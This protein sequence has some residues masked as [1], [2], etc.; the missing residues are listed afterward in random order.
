VPDARHIIHIVVEPH[1]LE[2][3]G[4]FVD[5]EMQVLDAGFG[6]APDDVALAH[7][8]SLAGFRRVRRGSRR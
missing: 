7:A 2:G 3:I 6:V 4:V 5:V 1:R 8:A